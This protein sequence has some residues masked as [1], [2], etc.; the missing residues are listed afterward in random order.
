MGGAGG[1]QAAGMIASYQSYTKTGRADGL[2]ALIEQQQKDLDLADTELA[3]ATA[4]QWEDM[5]RANETGA[6]AAEDATK[7]AAAAQMTE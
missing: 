4:K 6:K 3:K 5:N 7:K 1:A 2:K